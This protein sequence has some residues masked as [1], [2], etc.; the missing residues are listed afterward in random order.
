MK[1]PLEKPGMP[2]E[3]VLKHHGVLGQKW[4]IRKET[5]TSSSTSSRKSSYK[6]KGLEHFPDETAAGL[7]LISSNMKKAYGFEIDEIIPLSKRQDRKYIAFV[8]ARGKTNSIHMTSDPKVKSLLLKKEKEGWFVNSNGHPIESII[9]HESAH[10]MFHTVNT[11]KTIDKTR[12]IAWDKAKEQALKDGDIVRSTK[13]KR[14]LGNTLDAQLTQ[15]VSKYS[16]SSL[17]FEETEAEM[18][19]SYHWSKNPPKFIDTFVTEMH[20]GMG[21]R[22]QPFSGRK[23]SHAKSR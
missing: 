12:K 9:T 23:V 14:L 11:S 7:K 8:Q 18:F 3:L 21:K 13:L 6:L 15:K 5:T 1:V 10:A 19:S 2:E 22:V 16:E 4:G 20:K 17:F